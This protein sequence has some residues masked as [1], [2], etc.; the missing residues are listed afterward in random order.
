MKIGIFSDIHG[1]LYAFENVYN[2]LKKEGC[3]LHLFLGDICGYYFQ[4]NEVIDILRD[5]PH[6]EALAGNHDIMF[7]KSLEDKNLMKEYTERYGLSFELLK[8]T[9]TPENLDFLQ[10]L[11][12]EFHL[13]RYG[14]AGFHGSPWSFL[15]EYVYPDSPTQRFDTL[16]YDIVFLGHTH[17]TMDIIRERIRIVNPGSVGQPRDGGWP[18][19]AVYD[20]RSEKLEVKRVNYNVNALIEDIKRRKETNA[21]LIDVLH[22]IKQ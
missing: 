7:L 18:S 19:Y 9:I 10:R 2:E 20:A 14:I 1:N 15:E 21:Y 4:Q 16:D 11:P 6:L 3:D 17:W 22:R 8:G 13:G 12:K 5:I